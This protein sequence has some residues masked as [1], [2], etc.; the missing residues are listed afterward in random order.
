[1]AACAFV[2]KDTEPWTIYAGVPARPIKSR[3]RD[4]ML[5]HAKSLGY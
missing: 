2:N 4:L 3:R 1:V 5:A